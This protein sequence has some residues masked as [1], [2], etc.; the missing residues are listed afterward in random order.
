VWGTQSPY[1]LTSGL[2]QLDKASEGTGWILHDLRR[3][4]RT[5]MVDLKVLDET[6]ERVLG[7]SQGNLVATYNVSRHRKQ[8]TAALMMLQNEILRI[9]NNPKGNVVRLKVA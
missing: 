8:K 4:G 5:L 2:K 6:A 1:L 9:V 3:T 7:H